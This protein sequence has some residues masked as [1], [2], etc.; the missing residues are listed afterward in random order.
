MNIFKPSGD[1]F[2]KLDD[3][4]ARMKA[5]TT[6]CCQQDSHSHT[7]YAGVKGLIDLW[8]GLDLGVRLL[9]GADITKERGI[10]VNDLALEQTIRP[11]LD[12]PT[13]DGGRQCAQADGYLS[14]FIAQHGKDASYRFLG[15]EAYDWQRLNDQR[16]RLRADI[17]EL[18]PTAQGTCVLDDFVVARTP[19]S[20]MAGCSWVY[21]GS[22][23]EIVWGQNWVELHYA[24]EDYH[25]NLEVQLRPPDSAH[26]LSAKQGMSWADQLARL[27][28]M[29]QNFPE[30]HP[31]YLSQRYLKPEV[32]AELRCRDR[33]SLVRCRS[34]QYITWQG[35]LHRASDVPTGS[36]CQFQGQAVR[37]FQL[38]DPQEEEG[39]YLSPQTTMASQEA[40]ALL[41]EVRQPSN[42]KLRVSLG[43]LAHQRLMECPV[44]DLVFDGWYTQ[45]IWFLRVLTERHYR[46][47]GK[48]KANMKLVIESQTWAA[49]DLLQRDDLAWDPAYQ[50]GQIAK[51]TGELTGYGPVSIFV[52][53]KGRVQR[54]LISNDLEMRTAEAMRLWE[55]RWTVEEYNKT[56]KQV[57]KVA[58]PRVRSEQGTLGV[59]AFARLTITLEMLWQKLHDAVADLTLGDLVQWVF[60]VAAAVKRLANGLIQL[61]FGQEY[62]YAHL[63]VVAHTPP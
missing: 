44:Q 58:S 38:V 5:A 48:C 59:M 39:I 41:D 14:Q 56:I 24:H 8:Q 1:T 61:C 26:R 42:S 23:G 47:L 18:R 11:I 51:L 3:I 53:K 10:P 49:G 37:L 46:W 36:E 34:N 21:D 54:V 28:R 52:W 20:D 25:D 31:L 50:E 4:R 57:A 45:A 40:Q 29:E 12:R 43:M 6:S 63:F 9:D 13:V 32:L 62:Q 60:R 7:R 15:N 22:Q 17:V 30:E 55:R 35:S 19:G 2:L 16:N 33:R 27:W